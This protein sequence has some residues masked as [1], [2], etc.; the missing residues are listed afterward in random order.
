MIVYLNGRFLPD[1]EAHISIFDHGFLVGDG[2]YDTLRVRD[3]K[4]VFLR[5]HLARFRDALRRLGYPSIVGKT[6]WEKIIA[7]LIRRNSFVEAGLRLTV[8]RGVGGPGLDPRSCKFPT[9]LVTGR[10]FIPPTAAQIQRGYTLALVSVQRNCARSTPPGIKSTS[11]LNGVLA[12]MEATAVDADE[13]LM[14]NDRGDLAE[15]AVSNIFLVKQHSL[16]TPRLD[17]TQLPGVTRA[18]VCS[19]ARS[20]KLRVQERRVK[21]AELRSANE[22][23]VTNALI[24][25][26]PVTSLIT[27]GRTRRYSPGPIT[28]V[29]RDQLELIR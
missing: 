22:I 20:L 6:P 9:I 14:L 10:P 23:F 18:V 25:V 7:N 4:P 21:P 24:G 3:G 15:G 12:K 13:A 11:C 17:G 2:V 26:M 16:V 5:A 1:D 8:T 29:L 28:T 19:L 27:A